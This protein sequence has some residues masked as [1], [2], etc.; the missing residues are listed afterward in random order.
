MRVKRCDDD[1]QSQENRKTPIVYCTRT[2]RSRKILIDVWHKT[3]L[4]ITRFDRLSFVA[5]KLCSKNG[6][7]IS[8]HT[9]FLNIK[10]CRIF[11]LL[12]IG[13][14]L[15]GKKSQQIVLY[16]RILLS[17]S[18]CLTT[19]MLLGD[20]NSVLLTTSQESHAFLSVLTTSINIYYL[21]TANVS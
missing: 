14:I 12:F 16:C 2:E 10:I 20:S 1:T 15:G 4:L 17:A 21:T 6:P 3:H 18:V 11:I 5:G 9:E 13:N 19:V 7:G 8:L